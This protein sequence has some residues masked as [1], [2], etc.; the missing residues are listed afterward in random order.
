MAFATQLFFINVT[1]Y[2][3]TYSKSKYILN[4][5][6]YFQLRSNENGDDIYNIYNTIK[7]YISYFDLFIMLNVD[8]AM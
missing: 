3:K 8:I 5:I 6:V 2:N 1:S 4:R 7:L